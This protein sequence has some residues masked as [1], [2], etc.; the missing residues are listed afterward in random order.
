MRWEAR[1]RRVCSMHLIRGPQS[2]TA[3]RVID[4]M[5]CPEGLTSSTVRGLPKQPFL[6][7]CEVDRNILKSSCS[8]GKKK[9]PKPKLLGPDIF[10]WGGG[11]LR[12]GVGAKM[13]G[14]SFETQE[15]QTFWR[16]IPGFCRDIPGVPEKFEKKRFVFISRPLVVWEFAGVG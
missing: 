12:E 9:E 10:G 7:H 6:A 11:L 4:F 1:K 14:M 5:G 15:N 13:F 2:V 8:S 3:F 16:D